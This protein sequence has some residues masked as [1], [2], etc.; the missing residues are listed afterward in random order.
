[1]SKSFHIPDYELVFEIARGSYGQVWLAR[2]VLGAWRAVKIVQRDLFDDARPYN[3]EFN[4][5]RFYEAVSRGHQGL[6]DVL[7][8]GRNDEK[9]YFY[10]V[11]D[12][13]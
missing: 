3:R 5:I 9:G 4:G 13:V 7:H 1:M 2:S 11:F 12:I 8:V 6:I 10:Y